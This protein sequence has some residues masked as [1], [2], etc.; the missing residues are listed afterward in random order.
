MPMAVQKYVADFLN[1]WDR[2]RHIFA[3]ENTI[4]RR[5]KCRNIATSLANACL[6]RRNRNQRPF[7]SILNTSW[8]FSSR[9]LSETGAQI[10]R[11]AALPD[12]T[13]TG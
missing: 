13:M 1:R 12:D 8:K 3:E 2:A 7:S 11:F 10:L 6:T 9:I 4:G 5:T